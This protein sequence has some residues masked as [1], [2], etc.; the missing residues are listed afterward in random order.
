MEM[1]VPIIGTICNYTNCRPWL[2]EWMKIRTI[3]SIL[4][5]KIT[6]YGWRIGR[7]ILVD[8]P[9]CRTL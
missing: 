7:K 9:N 1:I 6:T 8:I 3:I 5:F 2:Y 4:S